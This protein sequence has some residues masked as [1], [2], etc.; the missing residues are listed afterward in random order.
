MLSIE[1]LWLSRQSTQIAPDLIGC[2][3]V[4]QTSNAEVWRGV[5]VETEAYEPDDP[6]MHAYQRRT[7]R[8]QVMFASA[9]HAYVY[10]IYG[11][12]HCLNVVTD[13]EGI[14]SSVL[15]RALELEQI[16]PWVDLQQEPKSHRVAA[17]PG[18]LCLALKIDQSLNST[19][20]QPG[21]PLWLE[22]REPQ[23]Q[24]QLESGQLTL[25][26][27][28]RIGLTKGVDLP[29]RWYLS[30]SAAVSKKG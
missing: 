8:N 2:T 18:K 25:T 1:A 4:R 23:F 5:I 15:I 6:A 28:T 22:H 3:L 17:G 7:V 11:Y 13:Q 29:R 21:Q 26:Q 10:R 9:G 24:Q 27:T 12:Y 19:L 30:S 14:A 16:P 20:L